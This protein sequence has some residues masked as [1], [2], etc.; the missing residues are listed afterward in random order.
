MAI[1]SPKWLILAALVSLSPDTPGV[2]ELWQDDEVVY[3]GSTRRL[4]GELVHR[5]LESH[6]DATHFAWEITYDPLTRE[7]ELLAELDDEKNGV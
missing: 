7:R 6:T 5:L 1:R 3:V 4:R 2:F